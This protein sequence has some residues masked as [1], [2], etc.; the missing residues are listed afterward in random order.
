MSTGETNSDNGL[1]GVDSLTEELGGE[2]ELAEVLVERHHGVGVP[3][4]G[5]GG[6]DLGDSGELAG[7]DFCSWRW[8]R[9]LDLF[10]GRIGLTA[11]GR[12]RLGIIFLLASTTISEMREGSDFT[13]QT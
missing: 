8:G 10:G 12:A 1:G 11:F 3:L 2:G 9:F 7:E 6:L 5:D 4:D 13:V